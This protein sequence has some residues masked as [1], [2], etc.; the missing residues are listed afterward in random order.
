[1]VETEFS[2]IRF[3]GDKAKADAVYQGLDPLSKVSVADVSQVLTS[4]QLVKTSLKKLSGLR[5]GL[6][7]STSPK[8]LFSL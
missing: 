5:L 2:V 6:L 4:P 7:T 8:S 1:M 3:R